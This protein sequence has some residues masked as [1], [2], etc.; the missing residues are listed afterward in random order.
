ML[1]FPRDPPI[2]TR[3]H[4]LLKIHQTIAHVITPKINKS[5]NL[6]LSQ[7]IFGQAAPFAQKQ[8]TLRPPG[9]PKNP[10]EARR[11][12]AY[13]SPATPN[14]PKIPQKRRNEERRRGTEREVLVSPE[15]ST[16]LHKC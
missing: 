16:I 4:P 8:K 12:D 15:Y 7:K 6:G 10:A 11:A 3:L 5:I 2:L 1:V 14:I 13:P 9:T